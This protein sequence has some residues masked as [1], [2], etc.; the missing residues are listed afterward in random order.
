[1]K[2]GRKKSRRLLRKKD[3]KDKGGCQVWTEEGTDGRIEGRR[4]STEEKEKNRCRDG[5]K[6]R[7]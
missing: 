2:D 5:R 6:E 7:R 4:G 1:M 3:I